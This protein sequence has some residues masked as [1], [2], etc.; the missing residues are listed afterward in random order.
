MPHT[1]VRGI[2]SENGETSSEEEKR[3]VTYGTGTWGNAKDLEWFWG[4]KKEK[5]K[6]KSEREGG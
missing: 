1:Q 2:L 6:E 3:T 5:E 4:E